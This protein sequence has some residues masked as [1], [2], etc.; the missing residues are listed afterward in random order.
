MTVRAFA[1]LRDIIPA[2]DERRVPEGTTVGD[3]LK[4]LAARYPGLGD[5]LFASPG[6]IRAYVNI[7]KNGRNIHF[8]GGLETLL[9]DGDTVALFPPAAGG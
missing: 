3:L 4:A 6:E 7:L 5:A 2:E 8:S 9:E 1:M